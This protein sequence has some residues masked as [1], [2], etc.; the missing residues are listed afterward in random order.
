MSIL[1]TVYGGNKSF[2]NVYFLH[3]LTR[4]SRTWGSRDFSMTQINMMTS[5][6]QHTPHTEEDLG[7]NEGE[8]NVTLLRNCFMMCPLWRICRSSKHVWIFKLL[9]SLCWV[10]GSYLSYE[11]KKKSAAPS[12]WH[13]GYEWTENLSVC[14]YSILF[15]WHW[16][17]HRERERALGRNFYCACEGNEFEPIMLT[18]L[19]LCPL[20]SVKR[21]TGESVCWGRLMNKIWLH[22]TCRFSLKQAAGCTKTGA[23]NYFR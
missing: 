8:F 2:Y 22:F 4:I 11:K 10:S 15:F 18:G 5:L 1:Y 19:R 7:F 3:K 23:T 20:P 16:H 17:T 9:Q 12:K 21:F 6:K 13:L 14:P